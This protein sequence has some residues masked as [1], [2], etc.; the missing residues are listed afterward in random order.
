MLNLNLAT[1]FTACK[2]HKNLDHLDVVNQIDM[3][4]T[5]RLCPDWD[6]NHIQKKVALVGDYANM[7]NRTNLRF[8]ILEC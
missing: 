8:S 6:L 7:K 4:L 2:N 3:D 1:R 5:G